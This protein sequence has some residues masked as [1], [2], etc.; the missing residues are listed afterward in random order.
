[1]AE[2]EEKKPKTSG[3]SPSFPYVDLGAALE[4]VRKVNREERGHP[5]SREV[6]FKHIG[7]SA[8]SGPGRR[9][10]AALKAFDLVE[11]KDDTLHLTPLAHQIV[12]DERPVSPKRAK[13]IQK[14]ALSPP[15]H[16]RLWAKYKNNL[17]SDHQLR[18]ELVWQEGF[19]K[20]SVDDFI[21][22]Y[23]RTLDF[24]KIG[25]SGTIGPDAGDDEEL[26]RVAVGSHVQWESQG[27]MQFPQPRRVVG[28][29][30]DGQWV[31]VEGSKTGLPLNEVTVEHSPKAS[32]MN[33]ATQTPPT[34]PPANPFYAE[35]HRRVELP[36]AG[37]RREIFSVEEGEV[38]L[39]WPSS[40]SE[41]SARDVDEWVKLLVRKVKRSAGIPEQKRS[42]AVSMNPAD[43]GPPEEEDSEA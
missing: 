13:A 4:M 29:S 25:E 38:I 10:L 5:C 32:S 22:E 30:D 36:S 20:G 39:E 27:V 9:T 24:A 15:I 17:P 8:K 2:P 23:K 42:A 28:L 37:V 16:E 26:P 12:D 35:Q 6:A 34:A 11:L 1:M 41:A 18:H 21:G 31:F 19:N 14:A 33:P 7:I 3:R 43:F 40:M